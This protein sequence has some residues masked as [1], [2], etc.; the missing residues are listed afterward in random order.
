MQALYLTPNFFLCQSDLISFLQR[1]GI[2]WSA[3]RDHAFWLVVIP[4]SLHRRFPTCGQNVTKTVVRRSSVG[5]NR[6][7]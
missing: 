1:L 3:L 7:V 5:R 4:I 2:I 6:P